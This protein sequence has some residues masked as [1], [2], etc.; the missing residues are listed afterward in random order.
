MYKRGSRFKRASSLQKNVCRRRDSLQS[1]S[2]YDRINYN[3]AP[4]GDDRT[5]E[6]ILKGTV[7]AE[8][9]TTTPTSNGSQSTVV[10]TESALFSTFN[11]LSEATT[12]TGEQRTVASDSE[13]ISLSENVVL[14][15]KNLSSGGS[16]KYTNGFKL[17]HHFLIPFSRDEGFSL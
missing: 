5:S 8:P 7:Y 2:T 14:L 11:E 15:R 4:K 10:P 9:P 6:T 16:E 3:M 13:N 12:I 1:E 17:K